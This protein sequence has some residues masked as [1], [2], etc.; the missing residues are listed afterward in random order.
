[1]EKDTWYLDNGASN[2]MTGNRVYFFELNERVTGKV[3][4][5]DGSY[6]D[7]RGKGSVLLEGKT[8]EKCLLTD[9]YYNLSLQSNIISLGQ[10]TEGGCD[11]HM[12]RD[13]LTIHDDIGRDL[14]RVELKD[15]TPSTSQNLL[16]DPS[17][18][19]KPKFKIQRRMFKNAKKMSNK[20]S[21]PKERRG[22]DAKLG[23]LGTENKPHDE[24]DDAGDED[25][26]EDEDDDI[27]GRV[28]GGGG[29]GGGGVAGDWSG[30]IDL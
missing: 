27:G 14:Q 15:D 9:V 10:A 3:K 26:A 18:M 16:N 22:F 5:G 8:R 29:G 19:K 2:H 4:F 30:L 13:L 24:D 12:K 20:G 23:D 28:A 7:I 25:D 17:L 6:I 1:M 21:K 11:I